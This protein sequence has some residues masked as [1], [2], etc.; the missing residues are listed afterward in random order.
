LT[1]TEIRELV[2]ALHLDMDVRP[3]DIQLLANR[4]ILQSRT[5]YEDPP[6]PARCRRAD[7]GD[8]IRF[9]RF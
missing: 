1:D 5:E 3:P 9:G 8:G 6:D 2:D 7:A 4:T